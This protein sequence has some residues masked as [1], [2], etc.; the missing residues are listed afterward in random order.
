VIDHSPD[1]LEAS[2]PIKFLLVLI[3]PRKKAQDESIILQ[4]IA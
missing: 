2:H 4:R 3:Q 1:T